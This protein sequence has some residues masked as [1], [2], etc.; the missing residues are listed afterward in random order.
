MKFT[1][2]ENGQSLMIVA[3]VMAL[4]MIG[5]LAMALDV[6]NLFREKRKAQSAADAAAVAAAEEGGTGASGQSAANAV[7]K[8]NGFDT[9]LAKNP[10]VVTLSTPSSGNF[11][12]SS[13]V[14]ASVSQPIQTF[15]MGA[16]KSG[17]RTVTVSASS[18]AGGGQNSP[19]CLCLEG[20]AGMDLNMSNNA[21]FVGNNCNITVDSSSGNAVGAVGSASVCA[22]ALGTVS[23][24]WDNSGNINNGGSICG[25]TQIVQGISVPC[26]PPM[27]NVPVDATCAGA[28]NSSG[29]T[30]IGAYAIG[31]GAPNVSGAPNT[32]ATVNGAVCYTGNVNINGNGNTTTLE[33]GIYVINGGELHFNSGGPNGG[34]NGVLFYLTNGANLV[35]DNGANVNLVAGGNAQNG[36]GTAPSTGIYNG[37]VFYQDPGYPAA[38]NDAPADAGDSQ[39]ISIQ[40][41][42]S[43]FLSGEIL[44]PLAAITMGN[45]SGTSVTADIV[46]Q[47]LTMN[48]GGTLTSY[49]SPNLGTL[50]T[51]VAK[52]VQ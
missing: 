41:G 20:T 40:G 43:T 52:L 32:P 27:P 35:I 21:K 45:G 9:T 46:A 18:V 19:T 3:I 39:P 23:T 10:A 31:P 11:S 51:S 14:Q 16:F 8:L 6:G 25:T 28:P 34:G 36:G 29:G 15:F 7:A 30:W 12:G 13:Y 50:S 17:L 22:Q 37:I 48:G 24:T 2:D 49:A 47:T 38:A 1:R 26:A 44:A 5:F 4:V 33:P 42:A